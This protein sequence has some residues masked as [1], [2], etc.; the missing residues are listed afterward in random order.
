MIKEYSN[1]IW[2]WE[3][4]GEIFQYFGEDMIVNIRERKA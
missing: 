3:Q 1:G 4:I 2:F